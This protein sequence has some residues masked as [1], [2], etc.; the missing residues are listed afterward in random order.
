MSFVQYRIIIHLCQMNQQN[1]KNGARNIAIW[2][3][4]YGP[5][6]TD[7]Q[8]IGKQSFLESLKEH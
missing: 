7:Q 4:I 2:A 5:L 3:A 6:L 8:V 1:H